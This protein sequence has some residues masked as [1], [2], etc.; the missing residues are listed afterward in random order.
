MDQTAQLSELIAS[1]I[2][3]R[4]QDRLEKFDK[5]TTKLSKQAEP[6]Q[7]AEIENKRAE[8]RQDELTRYLPI[9]WLADAANRAKQIQLVTHALKYTHSDAKGTSL[10]SA[11]SS[12]NSGYLSSDDIKHPQLDVVGNAAALDVG[13]L[14]MLKVEQTKLIDCICVGD[15][16]PLLPF[17]QDEAQ[18]QQ[19][20]TGFKAVV[21]T[22]APSSHKLAKQ[23][24]WPV[25]EEYH[26]LSPLF[27]TS[28]AQ[29]IHDE[30]QQQRYSEDG[31]Q[32][33][34][35]RKEGKYH[36]ASVARFPD[37]AVQSF[38][39]TK[40]QNI[41]QLNSSRYGKAYLFNSAPPEWQTQAKLPLNVKSVFAGT[42][43]RAV[44]RPISELRRYLQEVKDQPSYSKYRNVRKRMVSDIIEELVYFRL[45]YQSFPA[46]WSASDEC[47]LPLHQQLWLDPGRALI[48]EDFHGEDEKKEWQAKVARDFARYLNNQ[49]AYKS[50]L[51]TDDEDFKQWRGEA[52]QELR[53]LTTHYQEVQ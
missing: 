2:K 43:Q 26:L 19:W 13:K 33:N 6:E 11:G 5:E 46:G 4:E 32:A 30:L 29:A 15:V 44:Y 42:F 1:Y 28:M 39:G 38:G 22:D 48:D 14:L 17:A 34:D 9:H 20:L 27:A 40:P 52:A 8:L 16:S 3:G 41:S 53:L 36:H 12:A 50:D 47:K 7:Q 18:A 45:R 37:M 51:I 25:E 21:A 10:Y 24:Y 49:L 31:K 35:A 23:V